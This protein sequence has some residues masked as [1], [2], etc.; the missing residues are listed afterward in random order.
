[1]ACRITELVLDCADPDKLADFW[2][3]VLGYQVLDRD[4]DGIEIGRADQ[5]PEDRITLVLNRVKEP[6][7]QKLRMHVDVNSTDR[8]QAAELERLLALGAK[9]V[10]IGQGGVRWIVLADPEG[11]EFCLLRRRVT[12]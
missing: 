2:C 4:P 8:D 1:M 11:N 7:K 3:G 5:A 10:D 9:R 12:P 6:K